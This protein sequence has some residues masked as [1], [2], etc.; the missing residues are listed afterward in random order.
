MNQYTIVNLV[1]DIFKIT[2]KILGFVGQ[3]IMFV[4][5]KILSPII[6]NFTIIVEYI[7]G[8]FGVNSLLIKCFMGG[9]FCVLL[10]IIPDLLCFYGCR[11]SKEYKKLD[12]N[13]KNA[14][15]DEDRI[16]AIEGKKEYCSKHIYFLL[17]SILSNKEKFEQKRT[18]KLKKETKS[19]KKNNDD[20][21][22][23]VLKNDKAKTSDDLVNNIFD[24]SKTSV[25]E[26]VEIVEIPEENKKTNIKLIYS[27]NMKGYMLRN[28]VVFERKFLNSDKP[29]LIDFEKKP[30][31]LFTGH[32]CDKDSGIKYSKMVNGNKVD[33]TFDD[34]SFLA[35]PKLYDELSIAELKALKEQLM[36][37]EKYQNSLNSF[38]TVN[39]KALVHKKI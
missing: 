20:L 16:K 4:F 5:E 2:G 12:K 30:K 34:P 22:D 17:K 35:N 24:E 18:N 39:D 1:G 36:N 28:N 32:L 37:D 38:F 21:I 9:L 3:S 11:L 10:S 25:S 14:V 29:V 15:T 27:S 31:E 19:S 26:E 13:E 7:A 23:K 6:V 8:I 33:L